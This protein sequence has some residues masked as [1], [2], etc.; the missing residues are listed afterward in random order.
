MRVSVGCAYRLVDVRQVHGRQTLPAGVQGI[1]SLRQVGGETRAD[2]AARLA[3]EGVGEVLAPARAVV[4]AR[5]AFDVA[6]RSFAQEIDGLPG[7]RLAAL[8]N[9]PALDMPALVATAAGAPLWYDPRPLMFRLDC[10]MG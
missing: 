9:A 3:G 2:V 6:G 8:T 7:D 10:G 4:A 5:R 1:P